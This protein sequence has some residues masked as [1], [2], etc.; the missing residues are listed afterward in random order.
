MKEDMQNEAV[1]IAISVFIFFINQS[2]IHNLFEI[3]FRLY[4][5][6]SV[7]RSLR[8]VVAEQIKEEFDKNHGPTW[9]C[10][11]GRGDD[12]NNGGLPEEK[13]MLITVGCWKGR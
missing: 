6:R 2:V 1:N 13:M 4:N 9:H 8:I 11:V 12:V 10:I 5:N 7:C 3:Y